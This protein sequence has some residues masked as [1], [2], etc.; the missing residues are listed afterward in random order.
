MASRLC[1]QKSLWWT[2]ATSVKAS[3]IPT[4]TGSSIS[5]MF[6]NP[7]HYSL[8]SVWSTRIRC[9][10]T[11][12]TSPPPR[13]TGPPPKNEKFQTFTIK[14]GRPGDAAPGFG[15]DKKGNGEGGD[16]NGI[17]VK[18][19]LS[20]EQ[21]VLQAIDRKNQ[22]RNTKND[23][24]A[25]AFGRSPV[26]SKAPSVEKLVE[27]YRVNSEIVGVQEAT[28]VGPEGSLGK[29]PFAKIQEEAAKLK[30]DMVEVA[31]QPEVV[32]RLM[33]FQAFIEEKK[34]QR[35]QREALMGTQPKDLEEPLLPLKEIQI[36]TNI[37]HHDFELKKE[38]MR[39]F[40]DKKHPVKLVIKMK[41]GSSL[42]NEA[43]PQKA[44]EL[45]NRVLSDLADVL[46]LD[47]TK[48]D[49]KP[50]PGSVV[51]FFYPKMSTSSSSAKAAPD[52]PPAFK[53]PVSTH[54]PS[55]ATKAAQFK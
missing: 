55:I 2:T 51:K 26:A 22:R 4:R 13:R 8:E 18:K 10:A 35:K 52:A 37:E 46:A 40:L 17:I 9:L 29:L 21:L 47:K 54:A 53:A 15:S 11:T 42:K 1:L 27:R 34:R 25:S 19:P 14:A 7:V 16:D 44:N 6:Q 50:V 3:R 28:L 12:S 43:G 20:R 49:P 31:T 30:L 41:R 39:K 45:I 5:D 36:G 32:I 23:E 38:L 24:L 33:D 48:H